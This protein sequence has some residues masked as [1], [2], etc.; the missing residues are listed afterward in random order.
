V[1]ERQIVSPAAVQ[2]ALK[3]HRGGAVLALGVL[4]LVVCFI[5]GVIAWVMANNDLREMDAGAM[6]PAGRSMTQ[7]GKVCGIVSVVLAVVP[8]C[9]GVLALLVVIITAVAENM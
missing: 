1:E 3:P 5:M 9:I 8:L 2:R 6:D 4:G 7:A